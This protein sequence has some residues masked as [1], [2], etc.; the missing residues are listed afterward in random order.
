MVQSPAGITGTEVV[1]EETP[2]K[3]LKVGQC[4]G[5][6]AQLNCSQILFFSTLTGQS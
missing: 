1:A 6:I 2:E 5:N 3:L 4:Q